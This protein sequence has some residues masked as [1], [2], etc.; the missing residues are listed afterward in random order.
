MPPQQKPKK[1]NI[2]DAREVKTVLDQAV[3]DCL[4]KDGFKEKHLLTDIKLFLGLVCC[5]A[6]AVSHFYPA[7]FPANKPVLFICCA[8]YFICVGIIEFIARFIQKDTIV[9]ASSK[10]ARLTAESTLN[11]FSPNYKITFHNLTSS[12]SHPAT[13]TINITKMFSEDGTFL[14]DAFGPL[15]RHAYRPLVGMKNM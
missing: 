10:T 8:L 14:P 4:E 2:L 11:H 5:A 13:Q 3:V 6:A 1:A 7:K 12:D 9:D 15:L